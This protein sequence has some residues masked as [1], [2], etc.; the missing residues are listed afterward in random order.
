MRHC[1]VMKLLVETRY[2]GQLATTARADSGLSSTGSSCMRMR[3][4]SSPWQLV[5]AKS[6]GPARA[7]GVVIVRASR[8]PTGIVGRNVELDDDKLGFVASYELNPQKAR[9]LLALA[10]LNKH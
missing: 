4:P 8:V 1:M 9:I 3:L 5:Q 6:Q 7:A 10:L 2:A